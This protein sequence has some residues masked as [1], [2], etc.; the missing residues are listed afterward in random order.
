MN[1]SSGDQENDDGEAFSSGEIQDKQ[2]AFLL[3]SYSLGV[4]LCVIV[5]VS[6]SSSLKFSYKLLRKF[7][8]TMNELKIIIIER[9]DYS[10]ISHMTMCRDKNQ[11]KIGKKTCNDQII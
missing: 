3:D 11:F 9:S 5:V 1:I 10:S 7:K 8:T 6:A 2:F 4:F